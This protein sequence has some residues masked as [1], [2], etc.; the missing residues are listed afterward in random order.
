MVSVRVGGLVYREEVGERGGDGGGLVG[1]RG[2][3][4]TGGKERVRIGPVRIRG[5]EL[6]VS[7]RSASAQ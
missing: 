6:G 3:V 5:L 7:L 2:V 1:W 4:G